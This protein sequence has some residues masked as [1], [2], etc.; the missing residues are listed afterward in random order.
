[1]D[2]VAVSEAVALLAATGAVSGMGE[3]AALA[4]VGRVRK[5][6][7]TMFGEDARSVEALEAAAADP[8][9]ETRVQELASALRYYAKRDAQFRDELASW[10]SQYKGRAGS[11]SQKVRANRDAFVVGPGDQHVWVDR[12]IEQ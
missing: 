6:I 8:A 1:M 10:A 11:V 5:R 2:V 3:S 7:R 12:P 4:V 9:D